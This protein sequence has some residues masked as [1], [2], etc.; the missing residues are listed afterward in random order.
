MV[1]LRNGTYYADG[2]SNQ[3]KLGR[4]SLDSKDREVALHNLRK[5]DLKK[6]VEHGLAAQSIV[7]EHGP[8]S[9]TLEEGRNRYLDSVRARKSISGGSDKTSSRYHA[10]FDKFDRYCR[11]RG[12]HSCLQVTKSLVEGYALWLDDKGYAY[13]TRYL[14]VTTIKQF[15]KF[16][17]E[18]GHLPQSCLIRIRMTKALDSDA[19]CYRPEEVAAI[20][21]RCQESERLQWLYYVLAAL[22]Y[23]GMRISELASLRWS[24]IDLE[25]GFIRLTDERFSANRT[26]GQQ[27]R[28][29]KGKRGREFPIHA[30]L[31]VILA[32][33]PQSRDGKV[34]HGPSGGKLK[35]DLVR[36]TL[37]RDVLRPLAK[38]FPL[39]AGATKGFKDGRVH[40]FRHYFCSMCANNGVPEQVLMRW[41]GHRS[42][43][44]VRHYYHLHDE[45][46][47]AAMR[48]VQFV[49]TNQPR[50]QGP[51]SSGEVGRPQP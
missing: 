5:L 18:E 17:V 45:A 38:H 8:K 21:N 42:S 16:L 7:S 26:G 28:E 11:K 13:R 49:P 47:Q 32:A 20:L 24:D 46:S 27:K 9:L 51:Q 36:R 25:A 41:L 4:Y 12:V 15:I 40:S 3:V 29:L 23:T 48:S 1:G 14:E 6:A 37:I 34:L 10:I 43:Q 44:M 50:T 33:I 30:E 31:R 2:R 35:P 22:I 19:Y 39:P